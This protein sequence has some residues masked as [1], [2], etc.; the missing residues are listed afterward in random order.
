MATRSAD[1]LIPE[2]S[3]QRL[4][5]RRHRLLTGS[6]RVYRTELTSDPDGTDYTDTTYDADGRVGSVS[7]PCRSTPATNC[8]YT[9][10]TNDPL[11]RVTLVTEQDGST[12]GTSYANFPYDHRN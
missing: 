1:L 4:I 8:G 3:P 11:N 6:A 10:Y 9:A 12:I 5:I 7:N 2:R